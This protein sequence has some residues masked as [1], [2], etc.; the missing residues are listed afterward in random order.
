MS[1]QK[2]RNIVLFSDGT[3]N[4]SV[5]AQKSNV[6]RL[7]QAL[8]L[9]PD[10]QGSCRQLAFY[11]DGVGTQGFKPLRL[12]GGAFGWGLSRNVRQLYENLCRHYRPGDRIYIFG[13]S[14]GAFTARVLAHFISRC[15]ILDRSKPVQGRTKF[16][17]NTDR[18]LKKGVKRAYKSYRH[19]YWQT[20]S[21]WL[22][23][24]SIGPRF[25]RNLIPWWNVIPDEAFKEEFSLSVDDCTKAGSQDLIE[26]IGVWDTVDAVGLP[27]DELSTVLNS[28]IY[29]YK[30]MDCDFSD[31]VA[32]GRQ[33]LAIDDERHSFHPLLWNE[34][35]TRKDDT[36]HD[37]KQVWF[38]GMHSNVGGSYP[39][40]QLAHLSLAWMIDEAKKT[41]DRPGLK[42]PDDA[43]TNIKNQATP[44]GKMYDSRR[45]AATY[46]RYKP[47]NIKGLSNQ[48]GKD[49]KVEVKTPKIHHSVI[50]RIADSTVGY[51]PTGV[52]G[53]F[54]VIGNDGQ[55]LSPEPG[56]RYHETDEQ[57]QHRE[58]ILERVRSHI[59]WRRSAY[60][61][62]LLATLSLVILPHFRPPT[63]GLMRK[64][65]SSW[66]GWFFDRF[67]SILPN[68]SSYWTEAWVQ[69]PI[70]FLGGVISLITFYIWSAW[71]KNNI[72]EVAE[73]G[74]WHF[75]DHRSQ[76]PNI[77]PGIFEKAATWIRSREESRRIYS[78]LKHIALPVGFSAIVA[79]IAIGAVY[80]V[81]LHYP[82]IKDGACVFLEEKD[83]SSGKGMA[84]AG[85][86]GANLTV[87]ETRDFST[88]YPCFPTGM[89]LEK[90]QHYEISVYTYPKAMP[91]GHDEPGEIAKIIIEI[92]QGMTWR[93][94]DIPA[95][96][97][98]LDGFWQ[99][100]NP[101]LVFATPARRHLSLPW[102]TLMGE[103][104]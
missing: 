63:H 72:Q 90:G 95:G 4:S 96:T 32:R 50:D 56:D 99:I 35:N 80:R 10:A 24:I 23:V 17:M 82:A 85:D 59:F 78:F 39:E 9:N 5:S 64:G 20:A 25:L 33:A 71:V 68:F 46:Y 26:F 77:K 88:K 7:Y 52:P 76:P 47:R 65:M 93:D 97:D 70:C 43:I 61:Y 53:T 58:K 103:I 15:G 69:A 42:I 3:G 98:G 27:I 1:K 57:Q 49:W 30:F 62:L 14:R 29:P 19:Y 66:L 48:K 60:F 11:D 21:K 22:Q 104:G 31:D 102:F 38:A 74:W 91:K 84:E 28:V 45:G 55:A 34:A 51:A 81:F 16:K 18:G 6:W 44:L 100:F 40:D 75:K 13:F 86:E 12:L 41:K 67:S 92:G 83:Q 8:D 37:I 54:C 89:T 87:G 36:P 2:P 94:L 101:I 79:I 73:T